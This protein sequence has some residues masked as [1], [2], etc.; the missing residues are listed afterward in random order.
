MKKSTI[1]ILGVIMGLSFLSLLYLQ[2]SYIEEMVKMRRGQFEESVNRSLVQAV[3]NLEL[4]EPRNTWRRMSLPRNGLHVC[5]S[6]CS[7]NSARNP[8]AMWWNIISIR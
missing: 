1:W 5:R 3:H 7:S 4:V 2:V 6:S 8:P